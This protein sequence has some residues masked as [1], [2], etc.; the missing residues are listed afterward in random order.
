MKYN[1]KDGFMRILICSVHFGA[2]HTAHLSAY[3][4]ML[5]DCGYEVALYL[6][7]RY[8]KLFHDAKGNYIFNLQ[9]ALAFQPDIVWI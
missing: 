2:G 3:Q 1:R 6:D 8:M 5:K 9:D 4:K 7:D